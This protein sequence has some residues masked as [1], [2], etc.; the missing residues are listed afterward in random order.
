MYGCFELARERKHWAG[1]WEKKRTSFKRSLTLAGS[2]M[3]KLL[4]H[5]SKTAL[6][7]TRSVRLVNQSITMCLSGYKYSLDELA[8]CKIIY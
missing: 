7:Q 3:E 8:A 4:C 5:Y 1:K 6:I 2:K